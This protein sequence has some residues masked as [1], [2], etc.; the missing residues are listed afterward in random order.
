MLYYESFSFQF[1]VDCCCADPVI[2]ELTSECNI[3]FTAGQEKACVFIRIDND[4]IVEPE[5]Q[6]TATLVSTEIG[7]GTGEPG[8]ATITIQDDDSCM[9]HI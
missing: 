5:T 1:P 2:C 7:V 6:V 8:T 4:D 9:F 3:W